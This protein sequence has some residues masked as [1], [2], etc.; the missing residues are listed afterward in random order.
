VLVPA[1]LVTC[2]Y[3]LPEAGTPSGLEDLGRF[4][5]FLGALGF[6]ILL[7][8]PNLG[9]FCGTAVSNFLD[10]QDWTSTQEEIALRPI[11]RLIARNE[12]PQALDDLEELLKKH[13]PTYEAVL[14]KA[15]LVHH[16]GRVEETRAALLS[17][18]GLSQ[19]TAQQ[20]AVMQLLAQVDEGGAAPAKV[21][22]P[23]ARQIEI[24]HELLLFQI[25]G[26]T[27]QHKEIAAGAY[28][29]E[30]AL[31]RNRLWLKL[32]GENWG[33]EESCWRVIEAI[34]RPAT[35]PS[36]RRYFRHIA[37]LHEAIGKAI[38]GK[39]HIQRQAEA[40][41][42][43]NQAKQRI[44]QDDWHG[45]LPLL[46]EAS[47]RDPDHYEMAYR[48]VQ[49]VRRTSGAAAAAEALGRVLQR[50]R[51]TEDEEHMLRELKGR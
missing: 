5:C 31:C 15:K 25:E 12:I 35:A 24:E 1:T 33:N 27:V 19:S 48:W 7:L 39:S 22:A 14:L 8:A 45:A 20:S 17:L 21:P 6:L 50:S 11:R 18:I 41:E 9:H 51:W 10:P 13:K 29:V 42:L 49:A 3:F 28:N 32:A 2:V 36:R 23:G 37:R 26:D 46:Q 16:F 43:F 38:R 4:V 34:E 40:Q 44:R 30:E 47:A